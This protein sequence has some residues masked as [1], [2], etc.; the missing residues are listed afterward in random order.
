VAAE[1]DPQGVGPARPD[2]PPSSSGGPAHPADGGWDWTDIAIPDDIRELES[3][4]E[5]YRREQRAA[6][7]RA[8]RERRRATSP[9]GRLLLPA[10]RPVAPGFTARPRRLALP[11]AMT[12]GALVLS[13]IVTILLTM[14]APS[15][16]SADRAALPLAH[17]AVADGA[18]G[19][20][21]PDIAVYDAATDRPI[22][23]Q[24]VRPLMLLLH[25]AGCNCG[26]QL[27]D[28]AQDAAGVRLRAAAVTPADRGTDPPSDVTAVGTLTAYDD[29]GGQLVS[30]VRDVDARHLA[31]VLVGAD[32]RIDSVLSGP[33]LSGSTVESDLQWAFAS[34]S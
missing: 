14:L 13:A 16:Q 31:V 24:G 33:Q 15:T 4:V 2:G 20:L 27:Q 19:G 9:M 11:L 7:R 8:A 28:L 26:P 3:E 1:D 32:G 17:P 18:K 22:R 12:A 30:R 5:A 6:Q 34:D 25:P 29:P 21:L 23:L 10:D